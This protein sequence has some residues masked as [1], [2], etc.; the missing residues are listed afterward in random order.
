MKL[1]SITFNQQML[2]KFEDIIRKEWLVT[3]GLGGYASST[4]LGI[5]TRKYH[6][7]LVAALHPPK[8]RRV[9][10][11]KL[12]EEIEIGTDVY[13]LGANQFK[14]GIFPKGYEFLK[15]F[16]VSPYPRYVYGVRNI[17]VEK[18][19][20][21]PYEKN[22]VASLYSF[23]NKNSVD[24]TV[25]VYPLTSSRYF[26]SVTDRWKVQAEPCQK[27][28]Y[29]EVAICSDVPSSVLIV[30]A[31][32]GRYSPQAKWIE[33]LYFREE[34][35]RGESCFD[36]CYQPGYFEISVKAGGNEDLAL[37][38]IAEE[39]E[40]DARQVLADLPSTIY[41]VKT[42]C[43]KEMERYES[44]LN[45]FHG[46]HE[47]IP[48]NDWLSWLILATDAF[49][50]RAASEEQRA[51]IAGY[52]WFGTW[53]RDTFVSLPGLTLVTGRFGDARKLFLTF[54][55]YCKEG[56][57]PNFLPDQTE[58]AMYNTVDATLW[59][60]NAVLQY[61]KYSG[62]FTFVH[63][64]LWETLKL[65]VEKHVGGTLFNIHVDADG[66]LSHGPQLTWM[67]AVVDGRP[68]TPRAG[69]AVE[70]QA[71]WYNAL[72]TMELL[73]KKFKEDNEEETFARMA[74]KTR[75]SFAQKFWN[76]ERNCLY[77]VVDEQGRG[78]SLRPNQLLT[79]SLDFIMLDETRNRAIVDCVRHRLLTPYGLRTLEKSDP[80]YVGVYTGD[81][82]S[83]DKAYHNGTVWPWLIGP[84]TKAFLKTNAY[85]E[86]NREYAL[87]NLLQPFFTKH[88]GDAGLG[89]VNEIFD[90][91]PPHT[92]RGCIAQAWSVAEPFRAYVEDVMQIRPTYETNVLQLG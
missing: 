70:V 31:I 67:D 82:G 32:N 37:I 25:R 27:Y 24:A 12:D 92:P 38:A 88:I 18:T 83:R 42:L 54:K 64:Q 40:D 30:A 75:K 34:A 43:S 73:A 57:I 69:K 61:L 33:R 14:N 85:S 4:P 91:E 84:F 71:L 39:N 29:N 55:K 60:V 87:T 79:V 36:D 49:V 3:N 89:S 17:E 78:G 62:D 35:D 81:R 11:V 26:H 9:F 68:M 10:L 23:Q 21:M 46:T 77:D 7:L 65:I 8:D 56:L 13:S 59:Y 74:E 72:R 28:R 2:S 50:V 1:P 53:G 44:F 51:M 63:E 48:A 45:G 41:D 20:F 66:L 58:S 47:N 5:N 19:V 15:Q 52:H 22:A 90:G 16:S 80:R 6:G 76:A 86:S